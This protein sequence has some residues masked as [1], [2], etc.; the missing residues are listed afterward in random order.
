MSDKSEPSVPLAIIGIG[1]LFPKAGGLREFWSNIKAKVDGITDIPPSH[2]APEDYFEADPKKPDMTYARRGGFL[3]PVDFDPSE[4]GVTPATLEATDSAQ[5]LGLVAAQMA[6]KDAGYGAD[7]EFD[8]DKV[9]V[10]LGVTGTL[11]LVVPLG[12]RLGHPIWRKALKEHGIEGPEAESI[13]ERMKDGYVPWQENSF[14]GLLGNVVAGRIANRFN[15]GGTN[16]VVD[17]ACASSLGAAHLASLELSAR[18]SSMVVTG[19]VDCFNDIFMFMCFSK[20]PALSPTGDA[21]PFDKKADGTIL[22]EGLGMVVLKRLDDAERDG[23]KIYAVIKG[24]G[25]SSDGRGKSIYAPSA[26]GQAK[27]LRKAY[28]N[29]GVSPDTVELVEAHGTGTSVGDAAEVDAL[30][31]VYRATGRNGRWAALGSVKSMIGHTKA[32]AGSAGMIKAALSLYH[33]VLP[34]TLK[35]FEPNAAV[36]GSPFY[37]NTEKRPWAASGKHPRRAAI[38]ALGFGGSN[39][40][41]VLEEY[42]PSKTELDWDGRVQLLAFSGADVKSAL[43][44]FRAPADWAELCVAAAKTRAAFDASAAQRLLIVLEKEGADVSKLLASA[45][46]ALAA[47]QGKA[48]WSSPDGIFFGSGAR[49]KVAALFAGQGSQYVGMGRDLFCQFPQA[50]AALE[51]ANASFQ[52]SSRLSDLMDPP[53]SFSE[54][55]KA[56]QEKALRSTDVAQPALGAAGLAMH[57]AL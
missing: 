36:E 21:K 53:P 9:S 34:P 1:C 39:F 14:P 42:R 19:G 28:E 43:S 16:C 12:A 45:L 57:R 31:A 32:A 51:N 20:T 10:I 7:R 8:R 30:K 6:L 40:H 49:A 17:A 33:K 15:L 26:E 2:W 54:S 5:L 35:V 37:L 41:V 44:A 48:S 46:A 11:E 47:N 29:A 3:K 13:I 55:E 4:F 50:Q 52:G 27:A 18:R 24:V 22:G 38:S 25:S 23:D 56:E